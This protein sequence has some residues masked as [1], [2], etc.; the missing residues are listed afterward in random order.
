MLV[1]EGNSFLISNGTVNGVTHFFAGTKDITAGLTGGGGQLGG[2]LT[3]RDGDIPSVVFSLDQLA[4]SVSTSVNS[5]SPSP[6][7]QHWSR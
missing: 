5:P 2:Y 6:N 4:Y 7:R 3:A 1:S